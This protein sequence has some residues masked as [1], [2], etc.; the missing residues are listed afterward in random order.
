MIINLVNK[1][2]FKIIVNY[3]SDMLSTNYNFRD[4]KLYVLN[5]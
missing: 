4:V 3:F 1:N 2:I 5:D